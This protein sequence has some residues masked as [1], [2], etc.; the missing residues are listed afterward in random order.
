MRIEDAWLPLTLKHRSIISPMKDP[1]QN[2]L[3][4]IRLH[5]ACVYPISSTNKSR[6][7]HVTL[8]NRSRSQIKNVIEHFD[9]TNSYVK[10]RCLCTIKR[11]SCGL[12]V[13][14]DRLIESAHRLTVVINSETPWDLTYTKKEETMG[15]PFMSESYSLQPD[16]KKW[17]LEIKRRCYQGI[18]P[19]T[20]VDSDN[21]LTKQLSQPFKFPLK[22]E[23]KPGY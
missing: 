22:L 13:F 2:I 1:C 3:N 10:Q 18:K 15:C 6:W 20:A 23:Y 12:A 17:C 14:T 5:I 19:V 9:K 8:A 4:C 7:S 16:K 21:V 11:L